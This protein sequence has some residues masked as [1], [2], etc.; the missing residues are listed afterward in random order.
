[1]TI[2]I[3]WIFT[4]CHPVTISPLPY[5]SLIVS[6]NYLVAALMIFFQW[7]SL[8]EI[9]WF[10]EFPFCWAISLIAASEDFILFGL[11]M[12]LQINILFLHGSSADYGLFFLLKYF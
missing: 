4:P 5:L 3:L 1:M 11:R 10:A 6:Q 12:W 9:I 2:C 8:S 7:I